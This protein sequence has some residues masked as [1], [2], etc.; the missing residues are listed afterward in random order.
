L[1][2]RPLFYLWSI[3]IVFIYIGVT[4]NNSV[5]NIK[6]Q[7]ELEDEM[8]SE[9]ALRYFRGLQ[10]RPESESKP[11]MAFVQ[12]TM[13]IAAE[14]YR[15]AEA[16]VETRGASKSA[17]AFRLLKPL[18]PEAIA[19]A[20][21]RTIL[22]KAGYGEYDCSKIV[23]SIAK[24]IEDSL[25]Y[26]QFK[27][28]QPKYFKFMIEK[29]KKASSE[30]YSRSI[31]NRA[32][33]SANVSR[34]NWSHTDSYAVG[35]LVLSLL[36]KST[37]LIDIT[38]TR[39]KK[40]VRRQVSLKPELL[41]WLNRQH[42]KCQFLSPFYLPM[43]VKPAV[44]TTVDDGG[45][46]TFRRPILKVHC[47]E[48]LEELSHT[49]LSK[50][51]EA[52]NAMQDT[53]WR[54]NRGVYLVA[55]RIWN[56]LR[57]DVAKLPPVDRYPLP[58]KPIDIDTNEEA[59]KEW[60]KKAHEVHVKNSEI[61]SKRV[62]T[63]TKLWIAERFL[64]EPKLYFPHQLDW[65][66]RAYPLASM[67]NPQG[68]D[69]GAALL[70][71]AEGKPLGPEGWKWLA[72]HLANS[73]GFDKASLKERIQWVFDH[74]DLIL[75]SA[76]R[77]LEGERF[78]MQADKPFHTLAACFE[79]LGYVLEGE[80]YVSHLPCQMDGAANGLQN[81]SAMLRDEI[82]GRATGLIPSEK[83]SDIYASV[84][85]TAER[86]LNRDAAEGKQEALRW[87]GKMNRSLAKRNTMTMP[88][89]VTL[90]GMRDQLVEEV[91]EQIKDGK[92]TGIAQ[93]EVFGL[94]GYLSKVMYEAIGETV[95][96]ARQAM[97]WLKEVA[98]VVS[99]QGLP[100]YWTTP[101][102]LYVQQA[103][104]KDISKC[105]NFEVLGKRIQYRNATPSKQI[106]V[107]K[108]ALGIA[109]NFVHSMDAAHLQRTVLIAKEYGLDSFRF[110]HDSY[111]THPS[112]CGLL[113]AVLR[114]AF[115]EQYTTDVLEVFRNEI[116]EQL[117]YQ[118]D[119]VA[120][121]PPVPPKGNLEL[122]RVMESQYFFA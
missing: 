118:P 38:V 48:Y 119:L 74:Q 30:T 28:E 66:G 51:C 110:I 7:L 42:D 70:Q 35:E 99:S 109:P 80:S 73:Y 58:T 10:K 9:G 43:V 59:K 92:L 16:N 67:V 44:W 122:E 56:E 116:L 79:W 21:M 93:E 23:W 25:D 45:Y 81:F 2:L 19:F 41:D 37:G 107:Q 72:I 101:M 22:N 36:E 100:V 32:I 83:P 71:F 120:K 49:D 46:F 96:A 26:K 94:C 77:P 108:Q 85:S 65:R 14:A 24:D 29:C 50:V 117:K 76:L 82:G 89:G 69:L 64:E 121:I 11:G 8:R 78:W 39:G 4:M 34:Q 106:D 13:Q 113:A 95:V 114:Q 52:L 27:K 33:I 12:R 57:G 6:R 103:Y 111:G 104:R 53:P 54:I 97:D 88:Y 84:A 68:D 63:V 3:F 17:K 40:S 62:A 5:D 15:T 75:D 47:K 20:G 31:M 86:I 60:K 55:N 115:V 102:G 61:V 90:Y 91:K 87:K 112:D 105:F 1:I 98:K 18:E